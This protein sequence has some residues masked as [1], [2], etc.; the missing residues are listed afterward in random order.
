[1][2][3]DSFER[4]VP[5]LVDLIFVNKYEPVALYKM[6]LAGL[7]KSRLNMLESDD[8]NAIGLNILR[9]KAGKPY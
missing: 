3:A 4:F 2:H 8:A 7:E 5:I 1:M 6:V 9:R